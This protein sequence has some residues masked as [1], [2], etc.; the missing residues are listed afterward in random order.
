MRTTFN[1]NHCEDLV[2][3]T[4]KPGN[5]HEINDTFSD[6]T[7]FGRRSLNQGFIQFPVARREHIDV[8]SHMRIKKRDDYVRNYSI[9]GEHK[10]DQANK[11]ENNDVSLQG[12]NTR[13]RKKPQRTYG[14]NFDKMLTWKERSDKNKMKGWQTTAVDKLVNKASNLN[15]GINIDKRGAGRSGLY[16]AGFDN[17][18]MDD[19]V[20][21]QQKKDGAVVIEVGCEVENI[22]LD[23]PLKCFAQDNQPA[24]LI[25]DVKREDAPDCAGEQIDEKSDK[26]QE[27]A[28][29]KSNIDVNRF[30][31]LGGNMKPPRFRDMV[32]LKRR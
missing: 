26:V 15:R 13:S 2:Y 32:D 31:N 17:I 22:D 1:H 19:R 27:V 24:N 28:T 10:A 25:D 16:R 18:K 23:A 9:Y 3:N 8:D 7:V 30:T 21:E 14:L 20:E 6:N 11:T 12:L 5:P 29:Q 4:V